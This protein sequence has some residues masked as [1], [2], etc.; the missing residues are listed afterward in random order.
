MHNISASE[1][2]S[3]TEVLLKLLIVYCKDAQ[4]STTSGVRFIFESTD[5][6]LWLSS[7]FPVCPS[8]SALT[9]EILQFGN[10]VVVYSM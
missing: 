8:G 3:F 9:M 10:A 1:Y 4:S 2:L 5:Q 6:N 7:C